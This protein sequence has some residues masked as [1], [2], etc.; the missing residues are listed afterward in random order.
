M[1]R[2]AIRRGVLERVAGERGVKR[3]DRR[4]MKR[5]AAPKVDHRRSA[6]VGDHAQPHQVVQQVGVVAVAEERLGVG[7]EHVGIEVLEHCDL[8]VA[9]DRRHHRPDGRI[10]EGIVEIAGALARRSVT[11]ARCRVLDRLDPEARHHSYPSSYTL[12][13]LA[14]GTWSYSERAA[15]DLTDRLPERL[16]PIH[17]HVS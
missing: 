1:I 15:L 4:W 11:G 2:V 9:T 7:G 12:P 3:R 13:D 6:V 16:W 5:T 14:A 10:G 8:V 17:S